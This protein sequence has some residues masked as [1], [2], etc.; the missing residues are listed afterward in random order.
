M[1]AGTAQSITDHVP[2]VYV[3]F[4]IERKYHAL[5]HCCYL[6]RLMA[7]GI[8]EFLYDRGLHPCAFGHRHR[9]DFAQDY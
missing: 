5:Y 6:N 8:G 4:T 7:I 2:A 1:V 3:E 9:D